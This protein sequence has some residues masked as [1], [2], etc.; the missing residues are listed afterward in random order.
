MDANA[1]KDLALKLLGVAGI[2]DP[3]DAAILKLLVETFQELHVVMKDIR[4]QTEANAPE[5]WAGVR[6]DFKDAVA[7]FEAG[8]EENK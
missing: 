7:A 6:D 2:F 1:L 4:N 5:V 3:R 8:V